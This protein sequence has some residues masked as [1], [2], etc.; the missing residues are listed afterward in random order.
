[1]K[2]TELRLTADGSHTLYVQTWDE[3]Y[4]SHHGAIQESEHI[5]I[6]RALRH[7]DKKQISVFEV[8]FGTGLN[9]FL[10]LEAAVK[11]DLKIRYETLELFPIPME[12]A[13]QLN[14]PDLVNPMLTHEFE[15]LHTCHWNE[16]VALTP[17]FLF[18]KYRADFT[19]FA[20]WGTYD[21]I[22]FDA[23]S[24]EKQPEMWCEDRFAELYKHCN[25]GAIL[26]TYC[27]KGVV[28]RALQ[29]VG[30]QVERLDGPPGKREMLRARKGFLP[31]ESSSP[32]DLRS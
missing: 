20:D 2:H 13:V 26:T 24:P 14:Y 27:S 9:A 16:E 11:Q 29:T 1:M 17:N 21:V 3:T 6:D 15:L 4:H 10:T 19:S 22:Y 32:N 8:G 7:C 31:L 5:F 25:E 30:F 28:R 23:F 12:Q 18:T